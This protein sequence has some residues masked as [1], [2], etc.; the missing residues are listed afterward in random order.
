MSESLW[1][2]IAPRTSKVGRS[3][4]LVPRSPP[5][6]DT[7]QAARD[8]RRILDIQRRPASVEEDQRRLASWLEAVVARID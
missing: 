5:D 1:A 7:G 4:T 6:A 8:D 2:R 3:G